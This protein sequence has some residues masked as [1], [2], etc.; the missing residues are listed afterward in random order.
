MGEGAKIED[1]HKKNDKKAKE[2][3]GCQLSRVARTTPN[4]NG[5][6]S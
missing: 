1:N 5:R 3:R 6:Y 4:S 2:G